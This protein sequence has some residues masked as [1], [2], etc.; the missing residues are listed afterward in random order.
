MLQVL[1]STHGLHVYFLKYVCFIYILS[2]FL[3]SFSL[4]FICVFLKSVFVNLIS[5][6]QLAYQIDFVFSCFHDP[7][8]L[9]LSTDF[10]FLSL[11]HRFL[12]NILFKLWPSLNFIEHFSVFFAFSQF[13]I[14][15]FPWELTSS[16]WNVF[17]QHWWNSC[18]HMP[19]NVESNSVETFFVCCRLT[20]ETWRKEK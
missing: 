13:Y 20:P 9:G 4:D 8:S 5:Q 19:G 2:L 18:R 15:L 14:T 3:L 6:C 12:K 7:S 10:F 17:T 11:W 16:P 1:I